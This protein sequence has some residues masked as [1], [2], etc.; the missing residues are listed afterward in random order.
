MRR[1]WVIGIALTTLSSS[2]ALSQT[3]DA[4]YYCVAEAAGG[5][6]F[7]A[8]NKKWHGT[9]FNADD[10]FVLRMKFLAERVEKK[11]TGDEHLSDYVITLTN[12]G[13][14]YAAPCGPSMFE[15]KPISV[16]DT[17]FFRCNADVTDYV[18]N[19]STGRYLELY[20]VGYVDGNDTGHD[21]PSVTGGTC[22]KIN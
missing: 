14:S 10:K 16:P 4:A 9:A 3:K 20:S 15:Q 7:D 17:G 12:A 13:E 6:S 21:T 11:S 19:V 2:A 8:V 18:F 5:I 22:T 1:L